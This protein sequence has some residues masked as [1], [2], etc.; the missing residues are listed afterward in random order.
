MRARFLHELQA[1][2]ETEQSI[3]T[4]LTAHDAE[5]KRAGE[6]EAG[7]RRWL[8]KQD[9]LFIELYLVTGR[10]IDDLPC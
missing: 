4:A 6:T 3:R 10:I 9:A 2:G 8:H 7:A 1:A 5:K